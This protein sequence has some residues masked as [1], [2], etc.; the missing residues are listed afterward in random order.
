MDQIWVDVLTTICTVIASL[1]ATLI[2]NK[3]VGIPKALQKQ[4][5]DERKRITKLEETVL[6]MEARLSR[7]EEA[8][9]H[10]P[11]YR[12]QS[13]RIQE[14]LKQ[15]DTSIL[16]VCD[17][18][19]SV[20]IANGERMDKRLSDLESREKNSLRA[21][22]LSEYRLLTDTAKN[23]MQ[24]WSEME[25]HSFFAL[26]KD[27]E[28]LGGNDYVHKTILPAMNELD[29]IPMSDLESLKRLYDSRTK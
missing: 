1:A 14:Q 6:S 13:L 11:E 18:I 15:A 8:V 27:Y 23:P 3:L 24:A 28:S 2:F 19:K 9:G 20:V 17:T 7:V 4:R 10:Y 5:D 25:A 22:I 21:K 16:E 26:V 12:A 29:I